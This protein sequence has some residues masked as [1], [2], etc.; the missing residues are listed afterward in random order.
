MK[1]KPPS[2][3]ALIEERAKMLERF[4]IMK[5]CLILKFIL[6]IVALILSASP[7]YSNDFVELYE[8]RDIAWDITPN[9]LTQNWISD[10]YVLWL[11]KTKDVS[12]MPMQDGK[13]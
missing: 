2:T 12:I 3:N 6:L 11:G 10:I 5:I 13:N 1:I 7:C 4:Y 8:G 9:D